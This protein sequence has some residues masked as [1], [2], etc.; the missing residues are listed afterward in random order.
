MPS[1]R[2]APERPRQVTLAAW[3]IV[4]GSV[5]VVL[6]AFERMSGLYSLETQESISDFLSRSPGDQLGLSADDAQSLLR[7][8]AMMA[9]AAAAA[10]AI[11]GHRV[12]T[13]S[14]SARVGLTV[15]APA[16]LVGG[17][18]VFGFGTALVVAAV[19][20]LWLQPAK[21]WFNGVTPAPPPARAPAPPPAFQ[22]SSSAPPPPAF[23]GQPRASRPAPVTGACIV[24]WVV[25]GLA[26]CLMGLTVMVLVAAPD[27]VFDELRRQDPDLD[28]G[29]LSEAE[30][31]RAA[32]VGSAIGS[33]WCLA[34]VGFAVAT[35][36]GL[37]W[38]WV[39]LLASTVAAGVAS[40][41]VMVGSFVMVAPLAAS[42]VTVGLLLRPES[43]AWCRR[44]NQRRGSVSP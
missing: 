40:T 42:A 34:A 39:A 10:M 21:D 1:D 33:A 4:G 9:G 36:R 44:T 37:R 31:R 16:L 35:F 32:F 2:S 24:T 19:V 20:M 26:L 12:L 5:L 18:A 25:C 28:L 38:G 43:R 22:Q 23:M 17:M 3:L 6:S 29:G 30:V 27:A 41:F 11:L 7:V 14:R 8:L 13:R 15:L